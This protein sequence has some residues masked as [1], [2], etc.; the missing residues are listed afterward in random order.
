MNPTDE[1][2]KKSVLDENQ[3]QRLSEF[4]F[5]AIQNLSPGKRI[6][7]NLVKDAWLK[8]MDQ[9]T[10]SHVKVV[11]FTGKKLRLST[12]ELHWYRSVQKNK[13]SIVDRLNSR[14][15]SRVVEEVEVF[16]TGLA[17]LGQ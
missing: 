6:T 15:G 11:G 9:R 2:K 3:P 4:L 8:V 7:K 5:P 12:R 1:Y 16:F 14:F 13:N 17:P 10:C